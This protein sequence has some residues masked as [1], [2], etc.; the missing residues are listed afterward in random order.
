M[1]LMQ[2]VNW[3]DQWSLTIALMG[4]VFLICQLICGVLLDD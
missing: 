4:I 1:M 2:V 3:V